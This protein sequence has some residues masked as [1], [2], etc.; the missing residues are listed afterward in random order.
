M[1]FRV[2]KRDLPL[3]H[4]A[5]IGNVIAE[6]ARVDLG[7]FLVYLELDQDHRVLGW[8]HGIPERYP[9]PADPGPEPGHLFG[10]GLDSFGAHGMCFQVLR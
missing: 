1:R 10:G 7:L 5:G 2:I 3:A 8:Q 9:A 4:L 6:P